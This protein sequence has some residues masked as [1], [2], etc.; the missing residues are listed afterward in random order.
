MWNMHMA[1]QHREEHATAPLRSVCIAAASSEQP[2][3]SAAVIAQSRSTRAEVTVSLLTFAGGSLTSLFGGAIYALCPMSSGNQQVQQA[4]LTFVMTMGTF[5][6]DALFTSLNAANWRVLR[7][8]ATPRLVALLLVPSALD[9]LIT[10]AAT[11][12]LS[13][14]PPSLVSMLKSSMQLLSIALIGR[15]VQRRRLGVGKLLALW[16]V[17]VG[18]GV[19]IVSDLIW[20]GDDARSTSSLQQAAGISLALGA[21]FL[22]AWRNILEEYILQEARFPSSALLM[23][24]SYWSA[25]AVAACAPV[26]AAHIDGATDSDDASGALAATLSNPAALVFLP[27]FWLTAYVK[28]AGKFWLIKH[29]SALRQKV[30][31]IGFPFGTWACGLLVFYVLGGRDHRPSIGTAWSAPSSGVKLVGFVIILAANSAFLL[32]RSGHTCASLVAP[33]RAA[34]DT[35]LHACLLLLRRPKKGAVPIVDEVGAL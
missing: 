25:I 26:L 31:A 28:D 18:A 32:F 24:E 8:R 21:G 7:E 33:L 15:L 10:G 6:T 17:A 13:L 2:S 12:A 5:G 14:A 22:G 34:L 20:N 29:A 1:S 3:S 16:A 4:W 35:S 11:V 23:C 19:V 27:L 30:V 9:V